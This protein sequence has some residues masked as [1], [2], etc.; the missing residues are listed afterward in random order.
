[1]EVPGKHFPEAGSYERRI[2]PQSRLGL[3]AESQQQGKKYA[4]TVPQYDYADFIYLCSLL[5][6]KN[7]STHET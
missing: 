5:R 2:S 7:A 1:M 3:S 6:I 4:A